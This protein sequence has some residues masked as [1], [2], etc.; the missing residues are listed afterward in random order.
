M[1]PQEILQQLQG[2]GPQGPAPQPQMPMQGQGGLP[3]GI[4]PAQIE[5]LKILMQD[6]QFVQYLQQMMSE[7]GGQQGGVPQGMPVPGM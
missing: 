3:P 5:Q 6:P 1:V 7:M 2:A 4:D